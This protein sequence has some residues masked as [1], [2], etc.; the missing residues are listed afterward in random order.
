M[1]KF[2]ISQTLKATQVILER[3]KLTIDDIAFFTGHQANLRM[4]Q[5]VATRLGLSAEQHLYNV[6]K[7]GNQGAA[8][9]PAVLSANWERFQSGD[10]IVV[11]VVGSGLTWGSALL[12]MTTI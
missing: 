7:Y 2:A 8:G 1:Q 4:V 12:R 5:S 9:A 3:N 6:D 11:T 10:L